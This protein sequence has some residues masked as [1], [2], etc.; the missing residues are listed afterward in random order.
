VKFE[1]L[2]ICSNRKYEGNDLTIFDSEGETMPFTEMV[3]GTKERY[4][5]MFGR[6]VFRDGAEVEVEGCDNK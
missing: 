5:I 3:K 2:V 6:I 4:S 1:R